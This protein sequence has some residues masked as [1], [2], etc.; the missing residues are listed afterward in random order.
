MNPESTEG[1]GGSPGS[2]DCTISAM[3]LKLNGERFISDKQ[4]TE[5]F[6]LTR[7]DSLQW[8]GKWSYFPKLSA[9]SQLCKYLSLF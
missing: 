5:D 1:V 9:L 8:S 7:G 2:Y 6:R 3:A 4:K